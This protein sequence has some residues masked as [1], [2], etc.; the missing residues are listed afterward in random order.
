MS[1]TFTFAPSK[2][3]VLKIY[4]KLGNQ[5]S[6][7]TR[8]FKTTEES[9]AIFSDLAAEQLAEFCLQA[10]QPLLSAAATFRGITVALLEAG[11]PPFQRS[12][13]AGVA[14]DVAGDPLPRQTC[15]MVTLR[16]TVGGRAGRGRIYLPFP[17]ETHNQTPDGVPTGAYV[18][19]AQTLGEVF[20]GQQVITVG[21]D[22]LRLDWILKPSP[23]LPGGPHLFLATALAR[24][25]WATQKSRGSYGAANTDPW[26]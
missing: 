5:V 1:G 13:L 20:V 15:G 9:D 2:E 16:S 23:L 17:S 26:D 3:Y 14:G 19:A 21:V 24:Q 18:T 22:Q 11:A 8:T 12:T 4:C 6:V 7:N 10:Y 25:R